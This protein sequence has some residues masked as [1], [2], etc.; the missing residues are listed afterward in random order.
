MRADLAAFPA[1]G[2]QE[3]Y[4]VLS[5]VTAYSPICPTIKP[6]IY[7]VKKI[8]KCQRKLHKRRIAPFIDCIRAQNQEVWVTRLVLHGW[9]PRIVNPV[10]KL[11]NVLL[12][13]TIR[14]NQTFPI[15]FFRWY[16][17]SPGLFLRKCHSPRG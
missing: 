13:R 10:L 6:L 14:G 9:L 8:N 7:F 17:P 15:L 4:W 3:Q 12:N 16:R 5:Q 1:P 11:K 2:L